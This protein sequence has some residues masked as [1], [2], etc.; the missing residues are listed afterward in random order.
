[1]KLKAFSLIEIIVAMFLSAIVISA[2]YSGYVFTHKQ[3]FRFTSIKTEIRN[4]FQLSEVLNREFETSKRV[5]KKGARRLD[6][7]M[8]DKTINY[9]FE[10]D[11]IVRSI[12]EQTDTFFFKIDGVEISGFDIKNDFII[13]HLVLKMDD[14]KAFSLYKPYGAIVQIE[15]E[16]GDRY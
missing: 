4:Y 10:N 7:E 3:F 5:L 16:D 2:V 1:M 15:K 12:D 6:I 13:D 14:D 11:F 9:S 8:I